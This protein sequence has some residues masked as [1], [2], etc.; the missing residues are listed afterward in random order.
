MTLDQKEGES[1]SAGGY[2]YLW[3][4][5]TIM[6]SDPE[7]FAGCTRELSGDILSSEENPTEYQGHCFIHFKLSFQHLVMHDMPHER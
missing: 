2:Q 6:K 7:A 5:S 1:F 3:K 4:F